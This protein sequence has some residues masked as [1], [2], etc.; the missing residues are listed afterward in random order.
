MNFNQHATHHMYPH[1]PWH[2]LPA[3]AREL[4]PA[5]AARNKTANSLWEAVTDQ[6]RGPLIVYRRDANPLPQ[7]FAHWED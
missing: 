1:I 2:E 6:L 4:P 7:F 5:Y 3:Q